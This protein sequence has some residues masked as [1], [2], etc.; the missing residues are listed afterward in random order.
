MKLRHIGRELLI[1]CPFIRAVVCV[2]HA[3]EEQAALGLTVQTI[4]TA[5]VMG[6]QS[7]PQVSRHSVVVRQLRDTRVLVALG[8]AG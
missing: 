2:L 1:L 7:V 4:A 8:N 3:Q 6:G 5:S